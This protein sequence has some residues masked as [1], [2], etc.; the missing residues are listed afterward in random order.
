MSEPDI[1][2]LW[3]QAQQGFNDQL[4][5]DEVVERFAKL[6]AK[7]CADLLDRGNGEMC[8]MAEHIWCNE[9]RDEIKRKFGVDDE[10]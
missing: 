4:C 8:S 9:C 3:W 6:V 7:E 10:T 5:E 1:K 2:K